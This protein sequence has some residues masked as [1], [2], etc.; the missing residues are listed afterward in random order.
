MNNTP[1]IGHLS[2]QYY[3]TFISQMI[4][5]F[6]LAYVFLVRSVVLIIFYLPQYDLIDT[7]INLQSVSKDL[8][9]STHDGSVIHHSP[10]LFYKQSTV[11]TPL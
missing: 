9:M 1:F 5:L 6:N 10:F 7:K 3:Y 4:V 2:E 8:L 11:Y